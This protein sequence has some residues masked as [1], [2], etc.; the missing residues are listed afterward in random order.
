MINSNI[1]KYQNIKK[2]FNLNIQIIIERKQ[3]K[4]RFKRNKNI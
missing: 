3:N 1:K 2:Q 4:K